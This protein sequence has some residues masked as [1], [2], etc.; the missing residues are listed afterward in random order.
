MLYEV[1]LTKD[2][3]RDLEEIYFYVAESHCGMSLRKVAANE[4]TQRSASMS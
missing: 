1:S 2:A 4:M 3:E